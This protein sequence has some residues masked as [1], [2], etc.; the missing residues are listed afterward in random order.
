MAWLETL[1]EPLVKALLCF[2]L[3]TYNLGST[4]TTAYHPAPTEEIHRFLSK[5]KNS[6][7]GW[8]EI[9][10]LVVKTAWPTHGPAITTL[11]QCCLQTGWHPIPFRSATLVTIPKPGKRDQSDPRAYRLIALLSEITT[12]TEIRI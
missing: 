10:T 4:K 9:T 6:T 2:S 12:T 11:F 5:T 3:M 1:S 8:D 7:P